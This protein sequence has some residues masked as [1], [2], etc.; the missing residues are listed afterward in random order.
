MRSKSAFALAIVPFSWLVATNRAFAVGEAEASSDA[1]LRIESTTCPHALVD[2]VQHLARVELSGTR[3]PPSSEPRRVV[4][5]CVGRTILIRA[6]LGDGDTRQLDLE[7]T[8]EALRARVLAI[9]IAELVRDTARN[10]GAPKP[11]AVPEPLPP[12]PPV[13]APS[14]PLT[15]PIVDDH[16]PSPGNRLVVFTRLSN[17]GAGFEPLYGGGF[18]FSHDVGRVALGVSP[19]LATSRRDVSVGSIDL[20]AADLSLRLAFRFPSATA[21][22]ELGIGHAIGVARIEG[23]SDDPGIEASRISGVWAA[24]FAFAGVEPKLS[25]LLYLQLGAQ[26]GVVTVPV[27][28]QVTRASDS[29]V[30]G[31]WAGL[32]LGIGLNL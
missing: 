2:D 26:L 9:A 25:E 20:L 11:A 28:G 14:E 22:A 23:S 19:S 5:S 32:S 8:D 13:P 29:A 24:P 27:R 30:A 18:G 17:F 7:Q 6:V 10:S 4:L 15:A 12:A 1:S 31:L 16:E 3:L 21:P